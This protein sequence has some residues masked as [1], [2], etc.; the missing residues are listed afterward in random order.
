LEYRRFQVCLV[1]WK[2]MA[3]V[4]WRRHFGSHWWGQPKTT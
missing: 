3:F 1:S 2:T 4:L